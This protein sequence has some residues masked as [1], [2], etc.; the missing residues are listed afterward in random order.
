MLPI[1]HFD[2]NNMVPDLAHVADRYCD[3]NWYVPAVPRDFH[4]FMLIVSGSGT[5]VTEGEEREIGPG[6][7]IYHHPGQN[8]SYATSKTKLMHCFGVNFHASSLECTNDGWSVC[9]IE[10]LPFD[11]YS[12]L[13]DMDLLIKYFT[14]LSE[15]WTEAGKNYRLKCRSIFSNILYE[16]SVRHGD[17]KG[18]AGL[19]KRVVPAISHIKKHYG[20]HITLNQLAVISGM[21]KNYFGRVFKEYTG[22]TPMDY[23][24]ITRISH[25]EEYLAIGCSVTEA[26][27]KAGFDDPLH[28]SKVFKK[29]RGISPRAYAKIPMDY[30]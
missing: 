29:I 5:S 21:S 23:L 7:F 17:Q 14:N 22:H 9:N 27:M 15:V 1:E 10:K 8:Y 2:L 16:L 6:T 4:N 18:N 11:N 30:F 24:N 13:S 25:S 28:F 19:Y 20:D 3:T 26:S 12:R